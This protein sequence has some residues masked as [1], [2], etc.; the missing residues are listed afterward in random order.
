MKL[1]VEEVA[2]ILIDAYLA[3]LAGCELS[4]ES[5]RP[6]GHNFADPSRLKP[7]HKILAPLH[8]PS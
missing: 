4:E 6:T 2:K 7:I 3:G 8:R 1:A 5:G